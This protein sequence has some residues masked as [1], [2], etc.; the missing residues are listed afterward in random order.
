[1]AHVLD[2]RPGLMIQALQPVAAELERR[3]LQLQP[4]VDGLDAA[5]EL[6]KVNELQD[7]WEAMHG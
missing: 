5:V 3:Q 7:D 1:M 2:L 4:P 6:R